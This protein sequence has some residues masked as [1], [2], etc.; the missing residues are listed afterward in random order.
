[1]TEVRLFATCLAEE[2]YP[3]AVDAAARV[4]RE[5]K[6]KVRP[7][8]RAFCC[9]Q[10]A[11][12]EGMREEARDLAARFLGACEPGTPVV[13]PSGSCAAM[14]KIFYADLLADDPKLAAKAAALRPW[15]YEFS[16]FLVGVMKVRY[17][18]A[19]FER[20]VAYHPGC[21]LLREMGVRDEPRLL[22]SAVGGIRLCELRNVQECC[23]FGGMFSVKFPHIS[24][25]MVED[26]IIRIKESGA[27]TVV[28]NDC[29]CLMQIGGAMHR[30]GLTIATLHLA[31]VLASR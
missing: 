6:L 5:L 8:R 1:M 23:G 10:A 11:F 16:Q 26:K 27:E 7:M 15:V 4:L 17:L 13:I 29:G 22:L 12:N 14:V 30:Q 21:H 28:A 3:S 19:R 18:G 9:G 25:A 24:T 31:E 20:A 2:F